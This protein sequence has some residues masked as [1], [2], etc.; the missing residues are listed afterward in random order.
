MNKRSSISIFMVVVALLTFVSGFCV[1]PFS[2]EAY[3]S[4]MGDATMAKAMHSGKTGRTMMPCCSDS[5]GLGED[6]ILGVGLNEKIVFNSTTIADIS[7]YKP[8]QI[9]KI[10]DSSSL[11]APPGGGLTSIV[12]K[13]E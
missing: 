9:L 6:G 7:N 11:A 2:A 5:R 3:V 4:D 8:Q 13:K 10:I 12:V 1:T